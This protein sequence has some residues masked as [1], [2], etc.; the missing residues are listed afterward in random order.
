MAANVIVGPIL[1]AT[2]FLAVYASESLLCRAGLPGWHNSLATGATL[3]A[4][5]VIA[6]HF[7]SLWRRT[8]IAGAWHERTHIAIALD[9]LS[10]LAVSFT[11]LA[12][13]ALPACV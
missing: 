10:A 12:A 1:W 11:A 7:A 4:L 13:A 9:V 8:K 2:H 6:W 3:A 5:M